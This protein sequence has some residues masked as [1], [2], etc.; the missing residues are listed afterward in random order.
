MVAL[1]S[2]VLLGGCG[3]I[4]PAPQPFYAVRV[5]RNAIAAGDAVQINEDETVSALRPGG[6]FIGFSRSTVTDG[7][8]AIISLPVLLLG[9]EVPPEISGGGEVNGIRSTGGE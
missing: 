9:W 3:S 5:A 6:R 4:P 7:G 8:W 1:I 2:L